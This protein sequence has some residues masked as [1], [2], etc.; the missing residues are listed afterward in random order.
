MSSSVEKPVSS[1]D[2][3]KLRQ[4]GLLKKEEVALI[5]GD[6]IIAENVISKERRVL[7]AGGLLLESTRRVLRD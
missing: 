7:E 5:V 2:L 4:A 6:V 1:N 3:M